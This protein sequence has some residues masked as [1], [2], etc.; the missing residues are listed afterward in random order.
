MNITLFDEKA[1]WR[2]GFATGFV[3]GFAAACV[4]MPFIVGLFIA[5][6]GQLLSRHVHLFV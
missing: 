4:L 2:D 1:F 6:F 3:T 5:T